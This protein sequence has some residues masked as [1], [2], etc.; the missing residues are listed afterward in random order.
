MFACEITLTHGTQVEN[1]YQEV[2][3]IREDLRSNQSR[4]NHRITNFQRKG[5]NLLLFNYTRG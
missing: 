5:V 1:H 3:V 2:E 4:D